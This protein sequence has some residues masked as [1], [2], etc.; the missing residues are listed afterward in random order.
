M[1]RR[2]VI[3]VALAAFGAVAVSIA[4]LGGS[5]GSG[6]GTLLNVAPQP[7]VQSAKFVLHSEGDT[8]RVTGKAVIVHAR[9]L[10]VLRLSSGTSLGGGAEE[11]RIAPTL[12]HSS[13]AGLLLREIRL[14]RLSVAGV[15]LSAFPP[16]PSATYSVE[17]LDFPKG[18]FFEARGALAPPTKAPYGNSETVRWG[19]PDL[20]DGVAFTY[21][22][23]KWLWARHVLSPLGW[24]ATIQ[25]WLLFV[26][27][28]VFTTIFWPSLQ[29]AA[30]KWL[31][32]R[33]GRASRAGA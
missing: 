20:Q 5:S 6:D 25:H 4:L 29:E 13:H 24:L 28:G 11:V 26:I 22:P 27:G 10:G 33:L 16:E 8:I 7:G 2:L 30:K 9:N 31:A 18:S 19:L 21:T 12:V 3:G 14:S 15:P 1:N 23:H 17:L 32:G